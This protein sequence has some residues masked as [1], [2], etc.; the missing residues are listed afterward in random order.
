MSLLVVLVEQML[1]VS[2]SAGLIHFSKTPPW[3][4]CF[5]L[6]VFVLCCCFC[7]GA[8]LLERSLG[9][10]MRNAAK[11]TASPAKQRS[12]VQ[13]DRLRELPPSSPRS[14]GSLVIPHRNGSVSKW[15]WFKINGIP[16]WDRCTTHFTTY[17]SGDCDVQLGVRGFDPLPNGSV[18]K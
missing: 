2:Y 8:G 14:L 6:R 5:V 9:F 10:T 13:L 3:S 7:L 1:A 18:S 16:F 15:P 17:F 4:I 11:A 12:S